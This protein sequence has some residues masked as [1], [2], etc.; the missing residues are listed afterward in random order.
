[1]SQRL[2]FARACLDEK[3]PSTAELHLEELLDQFPHHQNALRLL[4]ESFLRQRDL[5]CARQ[6]L[7]QLV[8]LGEEDDWVSTALAVVCFES[9][10]LMAALS[11]TDRV[12]NGNPAHAEALF[13]RGLALEHLGDSPAAQ[14]AF[15]QAH[16]M[17]PSTFPLPLELS[18]ADWTHTIHE[19]MQQVSAPVRA[20]WQDVPIELVPLPPIEELRLTQPPITPLVPG[21]FDGTPPEQPDLR[22]RPRA[23]RL[24]TGNLARCADQEAIIDRIVQTLEREASEWMDDGLSYSWE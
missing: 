15:T 24:F 16:S 11:A 2:Q 22:L 4:A 10:D 12:L 7:D 9:C 5:E 1:V 20:F 21:L 14:G 17:D 13:L 6:V 3:D 23:L 19:A 18:Q 8:R